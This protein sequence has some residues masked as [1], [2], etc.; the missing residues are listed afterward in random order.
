MPDELVMIVRH[1]GEHGVA[2]VRAAE[3]IVSLRHAFVGD[4]EP[5]A[6]G[7]PLGNGVR[8]FFADGQPIRRW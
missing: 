3:L 4:E 5:T 8:K 1:G 2:S 7:D 6:F